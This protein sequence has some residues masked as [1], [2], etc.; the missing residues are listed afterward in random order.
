M[1]VCFANSSYSGFTASCGEEPC[2]RSFSAMLLV[3]GI[4]VAMS[5]LFICLSVRLCLVLLAA[6]LMIICILRIIIILNAPPK[7]RIR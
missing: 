4:A 6:I 5:V 1:A 7:A 2:A 3:A